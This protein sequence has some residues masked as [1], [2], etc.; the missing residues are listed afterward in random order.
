MRINH[1]IH[2]SCPGVSVSKQHRSPWHSYEPTQARALVVGSADPAGAVFRERPDP[3]VVARQAV[4]QQRRKRH[5]LEGAGIWGTR[6]ETA[7]GWNAVIGIESCR[8]ADRKNT[9]RL[10]TRDSKTVDII[11]HME[12]ILRNS[13]IHPEPS[14]ELIAQRSK[15]QILPP[16]PI[17]PIRETPI[18]RYNVT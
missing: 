6:V 7:V 17:E 12:L 16:Q 5:E 1:P 3:L 13:A 18:P 15:V 11:K 8:R 9:N 10:L 14:I 4:E 2:P